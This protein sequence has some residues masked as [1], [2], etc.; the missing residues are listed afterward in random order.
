MI[1]ELDRW[2]CREFGEAFLLRDDLMGVWGDLEMTGKP[3][4]DD[5]FSGKPTVILAL[6]EAGST[7][8]R[9]KPGSESERPLQRRGCGAAAGTA[10]ARGI[11]DLVEFMISSHVHAALEALDPLFLDPGG[12]AGLTQLAHQIVWRKH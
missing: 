1:P 3:A 10:A 6:S 8:P 4:G 2:L 11:V 5:L 12:I 7:P 9:R